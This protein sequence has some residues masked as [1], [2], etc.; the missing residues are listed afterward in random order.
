MSNQ[1]ATVSNA[2]PGNGS[3]IRVFDAFRGL[4]VLSMIAFHFCY[5]LVYLRGVEVAWFYPPFVDIWRASIS[6]VFLALAGVMCSFSR[7]NLKRAAKYGLV[8][9]AVWAATTIA[10][11]DDS[12]SFGII[13]CMAASTLV[14]A[15]LQKLNAAP[16]GFFAAFV[17]FAAFLLAMGLPNGHLSL[18]GYTLE[19]PKT[20]YSTEWL[21]WLGFPGPKFVSGDYYPLL[22]YGLMYLVGASLGPWLKQNL[23]SRVRSLGFAPLE[24]IGRH[25]LEVYIAHQPLLLLVLGLV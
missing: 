18:P 23:P 1:D 4:C 7:N 5:D 11:V 25:A 17:L 12:I 21:S 3:R 8:A 19:I 6:W 24:F 2:Q 15:L 16:K 9:F 20:L 22:P 14:Y 10:A 13:F